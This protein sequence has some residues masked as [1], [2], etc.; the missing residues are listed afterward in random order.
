MFVREYVPARLIAWLAR[1]LYNEPYRYAPL[2]SVVHDELDHLT[3]EHRLRVGGREHRITATGKKP[4]Y[5]PAESSLEHFFKEH[6]WGYGVSRAG[7]MI[8]YE[9]EHP[10]WNVYPIQSYQVDLD[11]GL[12]YGPEWA[13]L[14]EA[15]PVSTV[16]AVG[17]PILVYPKGQL[18]LRPAPCPA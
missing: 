5:R 12:V 17:S 14:A 16:L 2:S 3:I 6:H 11:W 1:V 15:T 8:R 4:A 7:Q 13:F 18:A 9:V 10:V